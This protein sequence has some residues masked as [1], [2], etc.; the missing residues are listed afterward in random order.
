[1]T[2][3]GTARHKRPVSAGSADR[4]AAAI[5]AEEARAFEIA[6]RVRLVGL[7]VFAIWTLVE[8]PFHEA[9][10]YLGVIA[11][12]AVFGILQWVLRNRGGLDGRAADAPLAT[13]PGKQRSEPNALAFYERV[14]M[15][16]LDSGFFRTREDRS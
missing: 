11:L 5:A 1:L 16:R 13:W 6:T 4:V 12:L 3:A 15:T 7:G 10:F 8:N 2:P 14:G 9:V